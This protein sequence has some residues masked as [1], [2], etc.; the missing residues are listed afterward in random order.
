MVAL[1][2]SLVSLENDVVKYV[3]MEFTH[4]KNVPQEMAKLPIS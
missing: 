3:Q 1:F 2:L 4:V